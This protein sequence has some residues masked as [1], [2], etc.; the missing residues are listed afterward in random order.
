MTRGGGKI[1]HYVMDK[2]GIDILRPVDLEEIK[3]FKELYA[4]FEMKKNEFY[5]I[6]FHSKVSW[7]SVTDLWKHGKLYI[8][9]EIHA[10][11]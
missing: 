11:E 1:L 3:P 9:R 8:K 10:S 5:P 6:M 7:D 2:K 4:E